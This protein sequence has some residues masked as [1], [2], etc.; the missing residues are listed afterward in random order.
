MTMD[1]MTYL[2]TSCLDFMN[3]LKLIVG[4]TLIDFGP[5]VLEYTIRFSF[6]DIERFPVSGIDKPIDIYL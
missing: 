5:N 6:T 1:D 4:I 2:E 3:P